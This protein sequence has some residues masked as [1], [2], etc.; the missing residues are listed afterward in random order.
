MVV[1]FLCL[2]LKTDSS[3]LVIWVLK[4]T[5][6][7]YWFRPQNQEG[8]S[9]SVVPQ[10]RRREVGARHASRSSGLLHLEASR[11]RVY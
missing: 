3:G 11:D 2:C 4:I 8:F 6:T 10:N 7:I 9:L 1:G 5:S